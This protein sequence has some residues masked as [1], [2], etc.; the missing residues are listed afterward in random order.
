M[1]ALNDKVVIVTIG[2]SGFGRA[3]ALSFAKQGAKVIITARSPSSARRSP[4]YFGPS[5]GWA[6][7]DDAVRTIAKAIDTLHGATWMCW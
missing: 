4:E 7:P 3:T 6:A 1:C 5:R 2:G